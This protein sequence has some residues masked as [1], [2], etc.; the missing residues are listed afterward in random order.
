MVE[1]VESAGAARRSRR[2]WALTIG[3]ALA[4][5][6]VRPL[7]AADLTGTWQIVSWANGDRQV[8]RLDLAQAGRSVSGRGLMWMERA[9]DTVPVEVRSAAVRPP[10]FQLT[11]VP[12][13]GR[14]SSPQVFIGAW[15]RD[16]MSGRVEGGPVRR[17]FEGDR[18]R[19]DE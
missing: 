11:I 13:G 16:E 7:L 5:V 12:S 6:I 14:A 9:G 18:P 15:Y 19:P 1:R 2:W 10:D 8:V 3:A 4:F 17:M